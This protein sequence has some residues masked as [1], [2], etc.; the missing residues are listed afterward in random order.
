MQLLPSGLERQDDNTSWLL[1]SDH[2]PHSNIGIDIDYDYRKHNDQVTFFDHYIGYNE[3]DTNF[4]KDRIFLCSEL[5]SECHYF[6]KLNFSV[7][8]AHSKTINF[9]AFMQNQ[10][11]SRILA[12]A[13]MKKHFDNKD[14]F[15]Y[16]QRF[17]TQDDFVN[18]YHLLENTNY[19]D[20]LSNKKKTFLPPKY[21]GKYLNEPGC[22]DD[23]RSKNYE[24]HTA[25]IEQTSLISIITEPMF[26]EKGCMFT[27]KIIQACVSCSVPFFISGHATPDYFEKLGFYAFKDLIDY[28]AMEESDPVIKTMKL[29]DDNLDLLKEGFDYNKYKYEIEHN[30]HHIQDPYSILEKIYQNNNQDLFKKW[31]D[32]ILEIHTSY[33]STFDL[34][35][36]LDLYKK[37][38]KTI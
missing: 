16:T 36:V 3:D 31:F 34:Q 20:M 6:K 23:G 13:W 9:C 7:V 32:T 4:C 30:F 35:P 22:G 37:L 28:S 26:W 12:S 38:E 29:L 1:V 33:G 17:G 21:I 15:F 25:P 19:I 24:V 27:E 2:I 8:P 18:L 5:L 10:R 11:P 14:N